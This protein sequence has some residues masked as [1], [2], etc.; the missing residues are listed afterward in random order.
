VKQLSPVQLQQ[1]EREFTA[2]REQNGEGDAAAPDEETL[3]AAVR[4]E[5]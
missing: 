3:L 5:L 1:F 2:W 4:A